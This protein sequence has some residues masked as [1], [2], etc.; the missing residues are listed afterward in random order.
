MRSMHLRSRGVRAVG[1]AAACTTL[2]FAG[3]LSLARAERAEA[4]FVCALGFG[5]GVGAGLAYFDVFDEEFPKNPY[6]SVGDGGGGMTPADGGGSSFPSTPVGECDDDEANAVADVPKLLLFPDPV[7]DEL[8]R[9][10]PDRLVLH[11][12]LVNR[13]V[14]AGTVTLNLTHVGWDDDADGRADVELRPDGGVASLRGG[15]VTFTQDGVPHRLFTLPA[16]EYQVMQEK[17]APC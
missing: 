14:D 4:C 9:Q 6:E 10:L 8:R 17:E 1:V 12:D 7:S 11:P 2:L 16:L 5:F 15:E 3:V 13:Q